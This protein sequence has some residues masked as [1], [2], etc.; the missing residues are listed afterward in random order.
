LAGIVLVCVGWLADAPTSAQAANAVS[1][2]IDGQL[3]VFDQPPV[4]INDRTL[5]PL[6]GILESLHADVQWDQA[7]MTVTATQGN[8]SISLQIGSKQAI[9]NGKL[10]ELDVAARLVNNRTMVPARFVSEALGA[11]VKWDGEKQTVRIFTNGILNDDISVEVFNGDG[12]VSAQKIQQVKRLI[13]DRD[14][15]DRIS[16]DYQIS[17]HQPI[18]IYLAADKAG[19]QQLFLNRGL[20]AEEAAKIAKGSDGMTIGN[21]IY[22]PLNEFP[23]DN[24]LAGVLAHEL[25]HVMFNQYRL[26]NMPSWV[27][28]GLAW[29]TQLKVEQQGQPSVVREGTEMELTHSILKAKEADELIGLID[30]YQVTL[31][32]LAAGP[33]YNI[34]I[35]DWVAVEQLIGEYGM[36]A[37][38]SYVNRIRESDNQPFQTTFGISPQAFEQQLNARLQTQIQAARKLNEQGVRIILEVTEE[39]QGE[40]AVQPLNQ[41]NVKM[42]RLQPGRYTAVIMPNGSVSGLGLESPARYTGNE[43]PDVMYVMIRPSGSSMVN[44][45]SVRLAG[46]VIRHEYG[47]YY[48]MNGWI[49]YQNGSI[50]YLDTDALLGV[51]I[52]DI[53][54]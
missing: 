25:V 16:E 31:D 12:N 18:G 35:Q 37:M 51:K 50:E 13:S 30:D 48:L 44:G 42:Y 15:L 24:A 38:L 53:A 14:I 6:R 41:R 47:K 43:E 11:A 52:A 28:E 36:D 3:Q 23:E 22:L 20:S 49:K 26:K 1:V 45:H 4:I 33:D 7:N 34:E 5:V 46:F 39:F 40:L 2:E 27:N 19:Y 29:H 10:L 54:E 9:K 8:T 21:V 32:K 17:F